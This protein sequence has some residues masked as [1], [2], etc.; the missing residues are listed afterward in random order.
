MG[1]IS[2]ADLAG[3]AARESVQRHKHLTETDVG[4]TLASDLHE[5][6]AIAIGLKA[7]IRYGRAALMRDLRC[8]SLELCHVIRQ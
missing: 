7:G 1:L 4:D 3:E 2:L 6:R 8:Q 5:A